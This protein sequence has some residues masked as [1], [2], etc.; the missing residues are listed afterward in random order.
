MT[1]EEAEEKLHKSRDLQSTRFCPIATM[2]CN[3]DC[4]CYCKGEITKIYK[5]IIDGYS[6][7]PAMCDCYI[8]HGR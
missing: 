1:K 7:Y 3:S 4:E 6:Y 8:L 5:E 2:T